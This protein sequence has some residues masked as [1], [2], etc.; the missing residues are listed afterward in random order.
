MRASYRRGLL[1]IAENDEPEDLDVAT[2][3]EYISTALLADLFGKDEEA[4]ARA[5]VRRRKALLA[6]ERYERQSPE[7]R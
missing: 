7:G 1:W 3:S 4:V 5:I 2:V 6:Q